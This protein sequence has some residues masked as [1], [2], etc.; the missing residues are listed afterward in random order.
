MFYYLRGSVAA[1]EEN[2]AVIDC[3]GV[4]YACHTSTYTLARLR[5]GQTET[6][7]TRA[8]IREDAFDLYGFVSKREL[9]YFELLI[10]VTGVGPKAA[11]AILSACTPQSF[12]LAILTNDEK[13]LTAAAGVG[14][15]LAQRIVLE[16]RDK[17]GQTEEAAASGM[18]AST[19]AAAPAHDKAAEVS[20]ALQALGYSPSDAALA[21]RGADLES[22]TVQDGIRYGLRNMM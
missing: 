14:K 6:L 13:A 21:L 3:G 7:Y 1:M 8:V 12:S 22:M 4:G 20:A 15:K 18:A 19:Q 2:L 10:A 9:Q 5:Q 17:L 11:L 16:L